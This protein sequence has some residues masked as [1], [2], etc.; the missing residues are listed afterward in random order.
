MRMESKPIILV[1]CLL[2]TA[3]GVLFVVNSEAPF[4]TRY[5][6]DGSVFYVGLVM[7]AVAVLN[8]WTWWGDHTPVGQIV[9]FLAGLATGGGVCMMALSH[10]YELRRFVGL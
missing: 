9:T 7:V 10:V 5:D 2:A 3:F 1:T 6:G 8:L 4:V